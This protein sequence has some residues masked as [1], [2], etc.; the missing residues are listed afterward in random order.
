VRREDGLVWIVQRK[1]IGQAPF[2]VEDLHFGFERTSE[3]SGVGD[4]INKATVDAVLA[5]DPFAREDKT[6]FHGERVNLKQ[7]CHAY[8]HT[9]M[10]RFWQERRFARR[11]KVEQASRLFPIQVGCV[12]ERSGANG[13]EFV[14]RGG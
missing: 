5:K 2:H 12:K 13:R 8:V 7:K 1:S 14:L 3:Q 10:M 6:R 4:R 9:N 11:S